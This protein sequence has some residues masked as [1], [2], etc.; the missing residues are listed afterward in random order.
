MSNFISKVA[1]IF[2]VFLSFLNW[3]TF[4]VKTVVATFWGKLGH[5]LFQ[6]LVT[7]GSI[8]YA[9]EI[10]EGFTGQI[11]ATDAGSS[12]AVGRLNPST[13]RRTTYE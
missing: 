4:K 1:Q 5:F 7:L 3:V 2:G 12:Y 6:H 8:I 10:K 13:P 9:L 11:S